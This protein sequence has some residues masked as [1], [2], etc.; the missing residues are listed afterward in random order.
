[1]TVAVIPCAGNIIALFWWGSLLLA[2]TEQSSK[3]DRHLF[4]WQHL[5]N[6][7]I[8]LPYLLLAKTEQSSN[9][10]YHPF[11]WQQLSNHQIIITVPSAGGN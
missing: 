1:M 2:V 11:C 9:N 6:F 3:I 10:D 4:C 5:S 8:M 7:R